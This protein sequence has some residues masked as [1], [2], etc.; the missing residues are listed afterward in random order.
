MKT[1]LSVSRSLQLTIFQIGTS[2]ENTNRIIQN[3]SEYSVYVYGALDVRLYPNKRLNFYLK[4][5]E[6]WVSHDLNIKSNIK[7]FWSYI[8]HKKSSCEI[9]NTVYSI[10]NSFASYFASVYTDYDLAEEPSIMNEA[11]LL[12]FELNKED[13]LSYINNLDD[14]FNPGPDSIPA[15]FIKNCSSSF[16]YPLLRLFNQSLKSGVFPD[17]WKTS[18]VYPVF[19]S[20]DRSSVT[21]YRPMSQL[22]VIPKLLDHII[23]D[24]LS[25]KF[26]SI[27]L[28]QQHGFVKGR[29]TVTNL[30]LF[31]DFS[32]WCCEP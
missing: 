25:S 9:P 20:G 18:F 1:V 32:V 2:H 11:V 19:K 14:N 13:L 28:E 15:S 17:V 26:S 24:I 5:I 6:I 29:S 7:A 4:N 10:C 16:Q 22:S 3:K 12:E 23:A 21:N 30:L 8:K 27:I 31:T